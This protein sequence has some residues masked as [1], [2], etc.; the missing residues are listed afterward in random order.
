MILVQ[1][2]QSRKTAETVALVDGSGNV[3]QSGGEIDRND[4]S[5]GQVEVP[6]IRSPG[7]LGC[8]PWTDYED[9]FIGGDE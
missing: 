8:D 7:T 4:C 9:S 5:P 1:P 3:T 6:F 2:Y